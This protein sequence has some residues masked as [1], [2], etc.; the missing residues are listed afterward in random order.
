L[1]EAFVDLSVLWSCDGELDPVDTTQWYPRL[2]FQLTSEQQRLQNKCRELAFDFATRTAARDR[3]ASHP[4]EN[5]S[6]LAGPG[7]C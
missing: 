1:Q 2:D 5:C 4:V 7:F 6:G 3:D